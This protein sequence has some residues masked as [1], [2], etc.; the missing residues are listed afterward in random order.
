M[1]RGHGQSA[2]TW[3]GR[4]DMDMQPGMESKHGHGQS[5]GT[6]IWT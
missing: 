1:Q 5:A 4:R 3:T 2:W 6:W